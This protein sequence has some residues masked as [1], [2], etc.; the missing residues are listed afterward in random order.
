ME[1]KLYKVS[2]IRQ[3]NGLMVSS[4]FFAENATLIEDEIADI[5][6]ITPCAFTELPEPPEKE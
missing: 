2:W 3:D 5:V 1:K 6:S 4:Y